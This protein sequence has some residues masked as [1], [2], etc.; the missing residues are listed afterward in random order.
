MNVPWRMSSEEFTLEFDGEAVQTGEMDVNDL[1]PSLLSLARLCQETNTALNGAQATVS[2]RVR[3]DMKRGSFDVHLN[4][5]QTA[6]EQ[7]KML[8]GNSDV[9]DVRSVL[10]TL[11]AVADDVTKIGLGVATVVGVPLGLLKIAAKIGH[12]KVKST[13]EAGP[14]AVEIETI[15]GDIF[16]VNAT[17]WDMYQLSRIKDDLE[18]FTG[19]L[20]RDGFDEMR[21]KHGNK[22]TAE[23]SKDEARGFTL[24]PPE[25]S[26]EPDAGTVIDV[27]DN[28]VRLW[29]VR[30]VPFDPKLKVW[31]F[32]EGKAHIKA[33]ML[34]DDFEG[35]VL[36]HEQ[37]FGN[38]DFLKV[39]VRATTRLENDGSST[40]TYEILRVFSVEPGLLQEPRPRASDTLPLLLE[41]SDEPPT[42]LGP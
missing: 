16:L 21:F 40:V 23:I 18:K 29:R 5:V 9:K 26:D 42:G 27:D 12:K 19:P 30:K 11:G 41:P 33:T 3:A 6:V 24:A 8:F 20:R 25:G 34:D 17:A 39:R 14:G 1:A 31:L 35:R 4:L 36:R 32:F 10:D 28:Q 13:A 37:V 15:N 2:V 7:L 38:G 22:I